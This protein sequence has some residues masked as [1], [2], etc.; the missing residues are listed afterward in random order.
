MS[1]QGGRRGQKKLKRQLNNATKSVSATAEDFGKVVPAVSAPRSIDGEQFR[2]AADQ[3]DHEHAGLWDWD[4]APKETRDLLDL[5][6]QTSQLTWGEVKTR[7]FNSK[8]STRALHHTQEVGTLCGDAQARLEALEIQTEE[9]FRLR[10]GN[11][12]RVWGY[13]DGAIFRIVWFDRHHKVC[14]TEN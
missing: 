4:L 9:V 14:P 12:C 2:W 5:L 11:L 6:A 7:K 13:I 10:H 1:G 3:I 8:N